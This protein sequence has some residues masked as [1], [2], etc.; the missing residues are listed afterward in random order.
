MPIGLGLTALQCL[1]DF[2][3]PDDAHEKPIEKLTKNN[4]LFLLIDKF[5]EI[6]LHP[7]KVDNRVMGQV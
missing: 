5:T 3:R 6:D 4:R 2:V 7:D 1:A